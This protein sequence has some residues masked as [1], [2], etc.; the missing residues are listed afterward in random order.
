MYVLTG[1]EYLLVP[2]GI[3]RVHTNQ[4]KHMHVCILSKH[5]IYSTLYIY[6]LYLPTLPRYTAYITLPARNRQSPLH[7]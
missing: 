3:Y 1:A 6:I 7:T 5:S 2:R 4:S